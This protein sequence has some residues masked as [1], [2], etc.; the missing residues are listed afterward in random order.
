M[1]VY[2]FFGWEAAC[3]LMFL[4]IISGM[5]TVI[6]HGEADFNAL[7]A[8]G[9][10]L[11]EKNILISSGDAKGKVDLLE[12]ARQLVKNGYKIFG[13]EGTAKF[14]REN[15]V[16]ATAVCWPDENGENNQDNDYNNDYDYVDNNDYY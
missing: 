8:T 15:G 7:I 12:P 9:Y 4:C 16:E 13:T 2:V 6:L 11:P 5:T 3:I 1:P 10:H 14:F